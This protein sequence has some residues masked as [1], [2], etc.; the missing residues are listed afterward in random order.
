MKP[1]GWVSDTFG[2][3][4]KSAPTSGPFTVSSQEIQLLHGIG[5]PL[6]LFWVPLRLVYACRTSPYSVTS[7][8]V[9]PPRAIESYG[10]PGPNGAPGPLTSW[11]RTSR[12]VS[13]G[14]GNAAMPS[15]RPGDESRERSAHQRGGCGTAQHRTAIQVSHLSYS[16]VA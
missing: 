1:C 3:P 6:Q 11:L 5:P 10:V 4:V 15:C 14:P 8:L 2:T 7:M 9:V 13:S 12:T 16:F